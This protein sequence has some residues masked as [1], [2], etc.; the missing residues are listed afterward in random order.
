MSDETLV[1]IFA[2]IVMVHIFGAL[3]FVFWK[4]MRKK[5]D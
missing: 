4:L 2:I 5:K 1:T 3:G